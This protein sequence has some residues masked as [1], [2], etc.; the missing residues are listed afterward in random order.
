VTFLEF[1]NSLNSTT[2]PQLPTLLKV[3]WHDACGE[4]DKAHDLAQDANN[5]DGS[6]IH[7]Y[8]HRKE[9][10]RSNAQYWY[11]RANRK[12]PTYSLEQEWEE[13]VIEFLTK[14]RR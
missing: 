9:G 14:N 1:K 12:M 3:L 5:A 13:I 4:W 7:A 6:W 11:Q 2:P 10:D 8:L